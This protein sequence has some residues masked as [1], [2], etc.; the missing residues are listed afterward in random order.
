MAIVMLSLSVT[1]YKIFA[2]EIIPKITLKMKVKVKVKKEKNWT[3]AMRLETFDFISSIFQNFSSPTTY[4][5]PNLGL[6]TKTS[7]CKYNERHGA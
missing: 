6:H 1:N 4:I 5:Y 2:N 3:C 7:T